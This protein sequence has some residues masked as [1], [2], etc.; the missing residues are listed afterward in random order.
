VNQIE[1]VDT[2]VNNSKE[3]YTRMNSKEVEQKVE[4]LSRAELMDQRR[5]ARF[6]PQTSQE[7]VRTPVIEKQKTYSSVNAE[8]ENRRFQG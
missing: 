4:T 5:Q 2:G 7:Q 8:T 1:E 6:R 3:V